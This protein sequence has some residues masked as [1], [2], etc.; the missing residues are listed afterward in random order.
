MEAKILQQTII[1]KIFNLTDT[2]KLKQLDVIVE[3]LSDNN[4]ILER[5]AKPMRKKL[6]IEQLKKEQNFK[7]INKKA[8][9]QKLE[10]LKIEE[11]IEDLI[12]MI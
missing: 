1:N 6:S 11:P 7:P 10:A 5:L 12:A 2:R 3:Q 9:F 4:Y 8:F